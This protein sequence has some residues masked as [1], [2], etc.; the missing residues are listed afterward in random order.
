MNTKIIYTQAGKEFQIEKNEWGFR[1]LQVLSEQE[2]KVVG[3]YYRSAS[4]LVDGLAELAIF[5]GDD[6]VAVVDMSKSLRSLNRTLESYLGENC[7]CY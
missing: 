7:E 4:E 2:A 6:A 1:I 5:D 3:G